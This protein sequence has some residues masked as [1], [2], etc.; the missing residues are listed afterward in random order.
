MERGRLPGACFAV[1]LL[2]CLVPGAQ[3][4]ERRAALVVANSTYAGAPAAAAEANGAAVAAALT[5]SGF[6]VTVARNLGFRELSS[7]LQGFQNRL[8]AADVGLVYFTGYTVAIG[9][10]SFLVP[11]DADIATD[12][13]ALFG[14]VELERMLRLVQDASHRAIVIV[15]SVIPNPPAEKLAAALGAGAAVKPAAETPPSMPGLL[16]AYSHQPG[17]AAGPS[18][19]GQPGGAGPGP[20][21]E[22]LAREIVRPGIELRKALDAVE[23]TVAA[24]TG[25]AQRPWFRDQMT[26]DFVAVTPP[27]APPVV[28]AAPPPPAPPSQAVGVAPHTPP[29]TPPLASD[30]AGAPRTEPPV[31]VTALDEAMV[32][33]SDVNFRRSPGTD[34]AVIR[35]LP[36]KRKVTATGRV[37]GGDWLR[38]RDGAEEGFVSARF[39]RPASEVEAE[40]ALAAPAGPPDRRQAAVGDGLQAQ[41][42]RPGSYAVR[43][44]QTVFAQPQIGAA[45]IGR[46]VPGDQVQ[47]LDQASPSSFARIRLGASE[48]YVPASVLETAEARAPEPQ[49]IK[50]SAPGPAGPAVGT[51]GSS[52]AAKEGSGSAAGQQLAMR[53]SAAPEEADGADG[54]APEVRN[55]VASARGA[56]GRAAQEVGKAQ[57]AARRANEARERA[58]AASDAARRQRTV[59][60]LPNGDEYAGDLQNGK[61]HGYGVYRYGNGDR[62]EGEWGQDAIVGHGVM[63]FAKALRYE[64]SFMNQRQNGYGIVTFANGDRYTGAV[65]DGR[66][67]GLG[68]M[69]FANGDRYRGPFVR[70]RPQGHGEL[71]YADGGQHLGLFQDGR[72]DGAGI[73]IY[74]DGRQRSGIW[75]GSNMAR[76]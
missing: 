58:L 59:M 7:T 31:E 38:V 64:G 34:A 63:S 71:V 43:T 9:S 49:A 10:N 18:T 37:K 20:Y 4:A 44:A 72:Q 50:A 6:G 46:V 5:A 42:L 8:A 41:G 56:A 2:C 36:A 45:G 29:A 75:N 66:G 22:A 33:E 54:L 39:L 74:P 23:R 48:G 1:I 27:P 25:N 76:N 61:R 12:F 62:Y 24:R 68:E 52:G 70:G 40:I 47:V 28:A 13:D 67:E 35:V 65:R 14:M 11:V 51:S 26:G 69:R 3:A 57:E 15:D 32:V 30:P 60:I 73:Q 17:V 21:A 19:A 55:A 53:P 16:V